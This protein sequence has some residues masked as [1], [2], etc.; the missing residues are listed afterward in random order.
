[1]GPT[2][3]ESG[4]FDFYVVSHEAKKQ[5]GR[6]G[7]EWAREAHRAM[8]PSRDQS[9]EMGEEHSPHALNAQR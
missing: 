8:M 5:W 1:M 3:W 7:T 4:W 9:G 6:A 2:L